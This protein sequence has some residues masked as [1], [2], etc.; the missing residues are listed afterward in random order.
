MAKTNDYSQ[1]GNGKFFIFA[2][3]EE[4]EIIRL[5]IF[6]AQGGTENLLT[7]IQISYNATIDEHEIDQIYSVSSAQIDDLAAN[8]HKEDYE[9]ISAPIASDM[10][11][12]RMRQL[13]YS[14]LKASN[15]EHEHIK[16]EI[17]ATFA[18]LVQR[19]DEIAVDLCDYYGRQILEEISRLN[20]SQQD[21]QEFSQPLSAKTPAKTPQ[22]APSIPLSLEEKWRIA[23]HFRQ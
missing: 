4:L 21:S 23:Q 18:M 20:D 16:R 19:V 22:K 7:Q 17:I 12:Y 13:V 6:F 9:M 3:N 8:L 1:F 14:F 11:F 2:E 5:F 15:F 10:N